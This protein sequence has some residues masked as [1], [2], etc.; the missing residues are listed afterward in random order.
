MSGI[1]K[2]WGKLVDYLYDVCI[3]FVLG[4]SGTDAA[5]GRGQFR[6]KFGPGIIEGCLPL[7]GQW[8]R[9]YDHLVTWLIVLS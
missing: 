3:R 1:E 2:S 8:E 7:A 9:K 5:K 4:N 6:K